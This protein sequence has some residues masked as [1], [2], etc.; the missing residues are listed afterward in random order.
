MVSDLIDEARYLSNRNDFLKLLKRV[1][2]DHNV[3]EIVHKLNLVLV[4]GQALAL[5]HYQYFSTKNPKDVH[6]SFSDDIDF[7]GLKLSL[8]FLKQQLGVDIQTPDAFEPTVNLGMFTIP[9]VNNDSGFIVVDVI[10]SVGGLTHDEIGNGIRIAS[11]D[12]FELPLIDPLLCLKSRIHNFFA[13]YKPDKIKEAYRIDIAVRCLRAFL[14]EE[15][16]IG[17]SKEASRIFEEIFDLATSQNG[18]DLFVKHDIDLLKAIDV[19]HPSVNKEFKD[20]R[21]PQVCKQI[22]SIRTRRLKHLKRFN[23]FDPEFNDSISV[24]TGELKF[25]ELI[26]IQNTGKNAEKQEKPGQR[27][28]PGK[29]GHSEDPEP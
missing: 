18:C 15:L 17:W 26:E 27:K 9:S 19:D 16:D 11:I 14:N 5:W 1:Y 13:V 21:Y 7:Y 4:G 10:H 12:G 22:Q 3:V 24:R 20:K 6:Y 2:A 23:K 25:N 28:S 29:R 8:Q